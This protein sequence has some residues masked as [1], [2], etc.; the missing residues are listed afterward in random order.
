MV[1]IKPVVID[2][3]HYD[4]AD[5]DGFQKA[6]AFGIVGVIHKASEGAGIGDGA[7]DEHR[8]AAVAAGLLWGAY[9]FIRPVSV[10]AQVELFLRRAKPDDQTL[11]ALDYE[12][13]SVTLSQAR[14]FI[15][16][17]EAKIGRD[18]VLYSG[19][20]IKENLGSKADSWWGAR[21]LW[22]AQYSSRPRVQRSWNKYW[23][24]QYTGDGSGPAPHAV[25]GIHIQG[26]LDISH[27]DGTADEL[28]DQWPG[29]C[30]T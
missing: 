9:H 5:P 27:F 26:G 14:D 29:K 6:R 1:T 8:Q 2:I 7:Y 12:V 16:R 11:L 20:T 18:C 13:G 23:L 3:S 4:R 25:P 17:V 28:R 10:E 30:T 15:E 21:R 24:W 22:L 19:N